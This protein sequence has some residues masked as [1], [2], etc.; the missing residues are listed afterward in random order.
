[1]H[2]EAARAGDTDWRQ[3]AA[4]YARARSR[5]ARPGRRAQPRRRDRDGARPEAGLALV[6]RV[7]P[8]LEEYHLLHAARAD[9][10]RR[11]D[12]TTEAAAAYRRALELASNEAEREF[13]Q[14][15]LAQ[16]GR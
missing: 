16:L 9:L 11:L 1:M 13:L 12:R 7:A 6:D 8:E 2:A 3:I 5:P 14:G 15:R 10:L 4:L